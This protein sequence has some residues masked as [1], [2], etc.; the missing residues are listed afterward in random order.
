MNTV[1][2]IL[3]KCLSDNSKIWSPHES[4]LLSIAFVILIHVVSSCAWLFLTVC[5]HYIWKLICKNNWDLRWCFSPERIYDGFS[6]EREAPAEIT[7]VQLN[8][9]SNST[10]VHAIDF[11]L[12]LPSRLAT[13]WGSNPKQGDLPAPFCK[14]LTPNSV[15]YVGKLTLPA[16]LSWST[17]LSSQKPC[18]WSR[19]IS[20][21][22]EFGWHSERAGQF[23]SVISKLR[24]Y[25]ADG[26]CSRKPLDRERIK[27]WCTKM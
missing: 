11:L 3:L 23:L 14:S 10:T 7:A 15:P 27:L 17:K 19:L 6:Q 4:I 13:L 16:T 2:I 24:S 12:T 18:W 9:D 26:K 5:R 20:F 1:I 22:Q 25:M 8:E 21:K